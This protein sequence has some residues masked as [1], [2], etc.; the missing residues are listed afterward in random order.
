MKILVISQYYYPE[1]F[2]INDIA[3]ELVRRGHQVTVLT[4]CPNYPKGEIYKGYEDGKRAYE[5]IEGVEVIR[6]PITPRGKGKGHLLLNYI[7][8][9]R[10]SHKKSHELDGKFDIVLLYQLTPIS[11]AYPAVKFAK[12]NGVKLFCYCLDLAPLSG[13]SVAKFLKPMHSL[14]RNFSKWA[15]QG[16][17]MIAVTS[18]DF[19]DYLHDLHGIPMSRLVYLPQHASEELLHFDLTKHEM[20]DVTDFMFAGNI[21]EGARLDHVVYAVERLKKMGHCLRMHFVGDGSAKSMLE[22]L[23]DRLDLQDC[24]I[25]HGRV[26]M[27]EMA[28]MYRKADALIVTLRKGQITV[29]GKVQAYMATGKPIIGAMD[30]SGKKMIEEVGCGR[31]VEAE[32]VQGIVSIMKEYIENPEEFAACGEKEKEYFKKHFM[33]SAYMDRLEE[34]LIKMVG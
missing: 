1:Q 6:C 17:D 4:G 23:V 7:S 19:I 12:R 32:D 28:D 29:P 30:G 2:L 13:N 34:L 31:C 11:Q 27:S 15:Y 25:F 24:V 33:L 26:P 22:T 3:P 20:G 18:K 10:L 21:G 5:V 8:Y 16:C 14:Y 9:M